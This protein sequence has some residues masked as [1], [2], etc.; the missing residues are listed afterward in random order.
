MNKNLKAALATGLV[1]TTAAAALTG[2][3]SKNDT[4]GQSATG[5]STTPSTSTEG[6]AEAGTTEVA[7]PDSLKFAMN[8]GLKTEDGFDDWKQ[9]YI[10]KTGIN[11]DFNYMEGNEYYQNIELSFAGGDTADVFAVGNDKLAVY[12]GQGAL[13]DI[14]DM[15][16][17]SEIISQIDPVLLESV[18]VGGRYYGVPYE[19]GGG[20]VTYVRQDWLDELGLD[21]PTTYDEFIDM[22]RAFKTLGSNV[23]PFTAAGL[24]DN[25]AEFYLREFYQDASPD[26]V[27]NS[28]GLWVDGMTEP[29]MVPALERLRDAY[30]EGLID[31]EVITNKTSTC[32][33]KWYA[34][35]VGVFTYWAGNWNASLERRVQENVPTAKVTAIPP[36]QETYYIKRVPAVLSISSLSEKPEEAFKYLIEYSMDGAEG[37][38]LFQHG[39]E[40]LHYEYDSTGA[41]IALAKPSKADEVMEKAFYSPV[42]ATVPVQT[43]GY[44][45]EVDERIPTS[46]AILEEYGIQAEIV[47]VSAKLSK[48]NADLLAEREKT[49]ANIVMGTVSVE[50]GLANYAT[51]ASNL[52]I[53][54]VIAELNAN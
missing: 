8:I 23:I 5:G 28:E 50:E 48:I 12:A 34:G 52:G 45:F 29:N 6:S 11:L 2:C 3:G 25:Q 17:N 43:A 4:S 10:N 32:R 36:I 35:D 41:V 49:V 13:L 51:R 18:K 7:K 33:D 9:E 30:A 1:L 26:F 27:K 39:V 16:E 38:T 46:N 37:S 31:V 15:V 42:L 20:T 24:V 53:E 14:T 22:L 44:A 21:V 54:E 40:G 47:P 19:R